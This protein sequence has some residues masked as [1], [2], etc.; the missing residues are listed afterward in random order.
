MLTFFNQ[1]SFSYVSL[2]N[3]QVAQ[4]VKNLLAV[5]ETQIQTLG[6]EAPLE[7]SMECSC[8]VFLPATPVFLPGEFHGERSLVGY[9]PWRPK[10]LDK[11]KRL[12]THTLHSKSQYITVGDEKHICLLE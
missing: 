8:L 1:L 3:S 12:N 10:E 2:W 11:T 6:Q 4:V 5:Q 9:S 7:K